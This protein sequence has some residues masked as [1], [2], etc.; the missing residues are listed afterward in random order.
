MTVELP[1]PDPPLTRTFMA[2]PPLQG[3]S[4]FVSAPAQFSMSAG[5]VE[6][7]RCAP[8]DPMIL[9]IIKIINWRNGFCP[10]SRVD[11]LIFFMASL[12]A[13]KSSPHSCQSGF[14]TDQRT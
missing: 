10:I 3:G 2:S 9:S 7:K 6:P 12:P 11:S 4:L 1:T 13:H 5:T 8:N 14:A